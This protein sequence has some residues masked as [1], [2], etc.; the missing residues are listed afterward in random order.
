M[1]DIE[2]QLRAQENMYSRMG[3]K[4]GVNS[5]KNKMAL[6][7]LRRFSKQGQSLETKML[8]EQALQEGKNITAK[9]LESSRQRE[10]VARTNYLFVSEATEKVSKGSPFPKTLFKA[11]ILRGGGG[12]MSG[13]AA[14]MEKY[15]ELF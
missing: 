14:A 1:A 2:N 5:P 10:Q 8:R 15:N 13:L 9:Q 7:L 6:M 4:S 3:E 11:P 12:G